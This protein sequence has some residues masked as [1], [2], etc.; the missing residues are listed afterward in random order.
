M[1]GTS[2]RPSGAALIGDRSAVVET[3]LE[4]RDRWGLTYYV[5]ADQDFEFFRPVVATLAGT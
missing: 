1:G 2:R 5:I 3:L 4:R